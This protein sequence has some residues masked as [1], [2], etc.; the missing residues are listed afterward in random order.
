MGRP[1]SIFDVIDLI[2]VDVIKTI[3]DNLKEGDEGIYGSPSF[4]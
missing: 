2:G 1:T 4:K 3:C